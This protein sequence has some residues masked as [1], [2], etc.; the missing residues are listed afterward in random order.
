MKPPNPRANIFEKINYVIRSFL[1][2]CDAPFTVYVETAAPALLRAFIEYYMLD[3]LNVISTW[4]RPDRA[5]ARGR[6][7]RK[8]SRGAKGAPRSRPGLVRRAL[9]FDPGESLGK[10]LPFREEMHTRVTPPGVNHLWVLYGITER[11]GYWWMV[12]SISVNFFFDWMSL[13]NGTKYCQ[14]REATVLFAH[15]DNQIIIGAAPYNAVL[16]AHIEKQR[17]DIEWNLGAGVLSAGQG[18]MTAFLSIQESVGQTA[19]VRFWITE[20]GFPDDRVIAEQRAT[21]G[22]RMH[23]VLSISAPVKGPNAYA[24]WIACPGSFCDLTDMNVNL[25]A[26][27]LVKENPPD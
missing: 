27:N 25:W 5:I 12:I 2:F 6:R 19:Q 14:A 4:A 26:T 21:L 20:G 11:I 8:G 22:P 9:R 1:D 18:A 7:Q 13:L 16:F 15:G 3:L 24:V 17:G 10:R 23:Q